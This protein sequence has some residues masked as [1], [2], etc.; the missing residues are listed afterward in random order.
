MDL[1]CRHSR[2]AE[3]AVLHVSGEI[4]LATLPVFRDH[5]TRLADSNAGTTVYVDLDGVT[6]LDDTGLGMLLGATGRA[7]HRGGDLVVVCTTPSLLE[8]FSL[9]GLDRAVSVT[10]G[11]VAN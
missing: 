11:P 10:N 2:I 5:L 9:T 1:V 8:R 3:R 4:D 7:R 6:V